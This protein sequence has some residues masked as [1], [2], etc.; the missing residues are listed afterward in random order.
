[1]AHI[2]VAKI[3]LVRNRWMWEEISAWMVFDMA[4]LLAAFCGFLFRA[5][6][7]TFAVFTESSI[8]G[9]KAPISSFLHFF[10]L[11]AAF[12]RSADENKR[13]KSERLTTKFVYRNALFGVES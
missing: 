5:T 6:L 7:D 12:S 10:M 2:P 3:L 11:S 8:H 13:C 1:M 4:E 9:D